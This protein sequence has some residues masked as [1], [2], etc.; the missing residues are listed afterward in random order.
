MESFSYGFILKFGEIKLTFVP[1]QPNLKA[2]SC[3]NS[4]PK[5]NISPLMNGSSRLIAAPLTKPQIV[6]GEYNIMGEFEEGGGDG[7]SS[8]LPEYC[9]ESEGIVMVDSVRG[10]RSDA[11]LHGG[12]TYTVPI[13]RTLGLRGEVVDMPSMV[14]EAF[15]S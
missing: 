5:P 7:E 13:M 15:R 14:S 1:P 6:G 4:S 8:S 2:A 3:A 11:I 10:V 12:M 9:S